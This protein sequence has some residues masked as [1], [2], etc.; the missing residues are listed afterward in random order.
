MSIDR[1]LSLALWFSIAAL[2]INVA[3]VVINIMT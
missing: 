1:K 2:V 3:A